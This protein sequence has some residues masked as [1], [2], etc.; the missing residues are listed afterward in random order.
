LRDAESLVEAAQAVEDPDDIARNAAQ[1]AVAAAEAVCCVALRERPEEGNQLAAVEFLGRVDRNLS[2]VL[3]RALD[4]RAQA[5]YESRDI[6][7]NDARMCMQQA[8]L[9]IDAARQ[10]VFSA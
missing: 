2:A 5:A 4:R 3:K 6:S 7:V 9:L 8:E 10:R 1:A